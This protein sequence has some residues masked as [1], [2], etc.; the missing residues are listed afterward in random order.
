MG[1]MVKNRSYSGSGPSQRQLRVGEL[2]RRSMSDIL[3]RG[4]IH[5]P[6]LNRRSIT[7]GEVRVSPDLMVATVYIMP[8][9]GEDVEGAVASLAKHKGILRHF[10]SQEMTLKFSPD[11]RFRADLTFAQLDETRRMFADERV[12]RDVAAPDRDDAEDDA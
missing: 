11:L 2:I 1:R 12:M 6:D 8:L 3:N 5:D 7:I 10:V 4:E 9:G